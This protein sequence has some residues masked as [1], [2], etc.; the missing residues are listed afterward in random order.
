[1]DN[2][3]RFLR[4]SEDEIEMICREKVRD[5]ALRD[6]LAFGIG[7]HHAVSRYYMDF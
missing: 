1:M 2:P 4:M 5:P 7:L 6:S 3:K